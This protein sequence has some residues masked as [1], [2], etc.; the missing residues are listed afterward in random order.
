MDID[1]SF[2]GGIPV[3]T[4]AGRFDG[5]GAVV[6]DQKTAAIDAE[7]AQ[8]VVDMSSVA[9]LSSLGIRSLVVLEKRL[10]ARDGG[11]VLAGITPLVERVLDVSGLENVLRIAGTRAR[12][13]QMARAAVATAP[14][15]EMAFG[16]IRATIRRSPP[17]ESA[18]EW[19]APDTVAGFERELLAVEVKD[20]GIAFGTGILGGPAAFEAPRPFVST[21]QFAGMSG[22]DDV[23]ISDFVVGDA[24]QLMPV[25]VEAA[26]GVS[27]SSAA[28]VDLEGS[29]FGL[30]EALDD[31]FERGISPSPAALGFVVLAHTDGEPPGLFAVAIAF[32]PERTQTSLDPEKHLEGAAG[33]IPLP[34][35]KRCIGSAVT[36]NV[37]PALER[38]SDMRSELRQDAALESLRAIVG[39]RACAQVTRARVWVFAPGKLRDGIDKLLTVNVEG[40]GEWRPE[41]DAIVRR[42]YHDCGSV[43]LTPLPGGF[44]SSTY[45]AVAYD[46]DGR[47]TLPSVVKIGPVALTRREQQANREY[48]SRFILNNGTSVLGDAQHG[49]WAGL[50][51]NFL[52]VNGPESRLVWLYDQYLQRSTPEVLALIERLFTRVL[53]PWYAQPRWEQISL[54]RDHTPLRLFPSVIETGEQ[55]LGI[56]ADTKEFVCAELGVTL[57]NPFW[58][59]K[60]EYPKRAAESRLWYTAVSHGDLNLRNVLVDERDNLYVID[61]SE[62]H[63]RNAVSD[64]ARLEPVLKFEMTRI[65]TD[66]DVRSL[67]EF[68][69]GLTSVSSLD[70]APPFVYRGDDPLVSRAHAAITLLRRY[71]DRATLFELDIVPYWVAMLEWTYAVVCYRQVTARHKRY[72]ACSAA[73][74]CRSILQLERRVG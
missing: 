61:F 15:I 44:M 54:Y 6:F 65:E 38:S 43:T 60:H 24:S 69:Q 45:K 22:E 26:W 10:K 52:G 30:L 2:D 31:I 7:S 36:L 23:A 33:Q 34:S 20:L 14:T 73:L 49:E 46:H 37:R 27:G 68:E 66:D 74:I 35:G 53:K 64:F 40:D 42:L 57:P 3:L 71:A 18:I 63:P 8:W 28:I 13:V 59:L 62:T 11:L 41:W 55:V 21:L 48:V 47:R 5:A 4:L 25:A 72:A 32:D 1:L 56:S 39:L 70:E 17:G 58:F 51:Y 12:A 19:W 9:Y 67:V 29:P 16:S 50:R